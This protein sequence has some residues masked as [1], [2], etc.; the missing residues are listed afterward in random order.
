MSPRLTGAL[1]GAVIGLVLGWVLATLVQIQMPQPGAAGQGTSKL[2]ELLHGGHFATHCGVCNMVI[3]EKVMANL[4]AIILLSDGHWLRT[5]DIGCVF[6]AK[7]MPIAKW[8]AFRKIGEAP[9]AEIVAIYVP[10]YET[11]QLVR[12]EDAYYVIYAKV[13]TPM[14]DCVLAFAD[15]GRA[16]KYNETVYTFDEMLRLYREVARE[17]GRPMPMWC[18]G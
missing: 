13:Q 5:D 6:R 18:R 17:K 4:S 1:I 2:M 12:A 16:R 14:K 15:P 11:G 7:L 9:R 10:D 8:P 3:P